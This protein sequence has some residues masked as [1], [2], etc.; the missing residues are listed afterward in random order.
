M[1][2]SLRALY[3]TGS[4]DFEQLAKVEKLF[5]PVAQQQQVV[6]PADIGVLEDVV[7]AVRLPLDLLRAASALAPRK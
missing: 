1:N 2:R 6:V 5:L 7:V 4:R 3:R